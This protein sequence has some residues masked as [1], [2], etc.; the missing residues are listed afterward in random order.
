[1]FMLTNEAKENQGWFYYQV[2]KNFKRKLNNS[3]D[4]EGL[5]KIAWEFMKVLEKI[6]WNL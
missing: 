5:L 3:L 6:D 4:R 1:M 2:E